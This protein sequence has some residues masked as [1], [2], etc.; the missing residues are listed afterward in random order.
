[1]L[2]FTVPRVGLAVAVASIALLGG[3]SVTH[4]AVS[5]PTAPLSESVDLVALDAHR[6]A[7]IGDA[8]KVAAL[9]AAVDVGSLGDQTLALS[10]DARPY[11]L[12]IEF[13][14][15]ADGATPALVD[16]LMTDRAALLLAT[17]GNADEVRWTLPGGEGTTAALTRASADELAGAPVAEIGESVAGLADLVERLER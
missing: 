3:C 6:S 17:I 15:L 7:Y 9:T 1:M 10:T 11:A 5:E 12:T 8:S 13:T 16:Q 4:P 2:L 14:S